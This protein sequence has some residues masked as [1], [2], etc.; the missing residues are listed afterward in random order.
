MKEVACKRCLRIVPK[1]KDCP[2]CKGKDMS[3]NWKGFVVIINP[4]KSKI[5]NIL[6][7]DLPGEYALKVSK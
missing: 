7:R 1:G 6:K 2:I 4:E 5:A 3:E